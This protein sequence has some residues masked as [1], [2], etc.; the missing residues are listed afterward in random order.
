MDY[1]EQNQVFEDMYASFLA[2]GNC[3]IGKTN[4]PVVFHFVT[5]NAFA[6]MGILPAMGALPR[7]SNLTDPAPVLAISYPM[8]RDQFGSDPNILGATLTCNGDNGLEALGPPLNDVPRRIVAVMPPK[9]LDQPTVWIPFPLERGVLKTMPFVAGRLYVSARLKPGVSIAAAQA[10]LDVIAHHIAPNYPG[11]YPREFHVTAVSAIGDGFLKAAAVPFAFV[12]LIVLV[13]ACSNV[14][15]LLLSRAMVRDREMALRAAV[16]ASRWRLARQLLVEST[17]LAAG[18]CIAALAFSWWGLKAIIPFIPAEI[19]PLPALVRMNPAALLFCVFVSVVCIFFC[20]LSPA[21]RA[22]R[23]ELQPRL[24]GGGSLTTA[25]ARGGKLRGVLVAGQ[26]ALS[27]VLLVGTGVVL[28]ILMDARS[29]DLGFNPRNLIEAKLPADFSGTGER[30]LVPEMLRRVS[31]LP[32][33][34]NAAV[35]SVAPQDVMSLTLGGATGSDITV[36]GVPPH[37]KMWWSGMDA[38][39]DGYFQTIGIHVLRGRGITADDV[40][41]DRL[42]AVVNQAFVQKFLTHTDPLGHTVSFGNAEYTHLVAKKAQFEIVGVVSNTTGPEVSFPSLLPKVPTP[43]PVAFLPYTAI[44]VAPNLYLRMETDSHLLV[45]SIRQRIREVDPDAPFTTV[46]FVGE[47]IR[48]ALHLMGDFYLA[49]L[50]SFAGIG[51]LLA[52]VGLF[53]VMAYTV[54][55][56]TREIGIRMAFGAQRRDVLRIVLAKGSLLIAAGL[57]IGLFASFALTRLV[58]SRIRLGKFD[59]V[60]I[61]DPWAFGAVILLI[62]VTGLGACY[63]PARRA[64][65][66]DPLVALRHE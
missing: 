3:R 5:P 18:A 64:A 37:S 56:Q 24:A 1:R 66:V 23:G 9:A 59:G 2:G 21:L 52:L 30:A 10:N 16:G 61:A 22:I 55:L 35:A 48:G 38:V 32:G 6:L 44:K 36:T 41:S 33:V 7:M 60:M 11:R 20:G 63:F 58:G 17:V 29:A 15:N 54:S 27:I 53:S 25:G 26:V 57:A 12:V 14:A 28:H 45:Q 8:W 19:L 51:L 34:K 65:E 46:N 42:V 4:I 40:S 49:I 31:L 50:G 13:I 62:A 43:E 39:N 47:D